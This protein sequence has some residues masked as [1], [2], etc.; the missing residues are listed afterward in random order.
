M[1]TQIRLSKDSIHRRMTSGVT[2]GKSQYNMIID[3]IQ[4]IELSRGCPHDCPYCYE[5][6][7]MEQFP[8]PAITRNHVE[9]LDMN[10]LYQPNILDRIKELGM[11]RVKEKKVYYEAVCGFDYRL[12]TEDIALALKGSGF[13]NIRLAWDWFMKDQYKIK[14]AIDLLRSAGYKTGKKSEISLFMIVNYKIP[15]EECCKKLDLMKVWNVLVCD[16]CYDG[17]YNI[18]VPEYWSGEQIKLFRAKCRKHN[19]LINFGIDP[20]V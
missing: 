7:L 15:Y 3:D 13:V 18:A 14:D 1:E 17:G 16:C 10:F 12:L 6:T 20:E 8:I 4:R 19:Q 11:Y 2:Y 9:I 5:P